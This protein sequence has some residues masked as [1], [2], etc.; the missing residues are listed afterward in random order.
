ME[1]LIKKTVEENSPRQQKIKWNKIQSVFENTYENPL[2]IQTVLFD[3]EKFTM[4]S[5]IKFLKRNNLN[6]NKV[7]IPETG[8]YLRFRQYAPIHFEK[9]SY[10]TMPFGKKDGILVIYAQEKDK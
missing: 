2:K 3:K 1:L 10:R 7:D 5:A 8:K 9:G 4:N 6:Y